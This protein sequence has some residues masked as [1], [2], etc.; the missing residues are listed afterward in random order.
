MEKKRVCQVCK[1]DIGVWCEQN[2]KN[3]LIVHD[4]FLEISKRSTVRRCFK[5]NNLKIGREVARK[6]VANV[7]FYKKKELPKE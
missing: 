5:E 2:S 7:I 1:D 6:E 4:G 3:E